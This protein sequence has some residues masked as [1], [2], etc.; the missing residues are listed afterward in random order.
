MRRLVIGQ[1]SEAGGL[2]A[3]L[4]VLSPILFG[5]AV[6]LVAL[7]VLNPG[8]LRVGSQAALILLGPLFVIAC[9]MFLYAVFAQRTL[10]TA[11]FDLDARELTLVETTLLSRTSETVPFAELADLRVRQD[12]DRDGYPYRIAELVWRNGEILPL[13]ETTDAT[14]LALAQAA[15]RRG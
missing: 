7:A 15:L 13:P 1:E 9:G 8:V 6:P 2:G 4:H 3:R 14:T 11:V 12:Y 5:F 10:A